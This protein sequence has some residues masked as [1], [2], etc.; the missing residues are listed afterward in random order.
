MQKP[1]QFELQPSV[2]NI[3]E[4]KRADSGS[5][6]SS[7]AAA[8]IFE[9][10]NLNHTNVWEETRHLMIPAHNAGEFKLLSNH[11]ESGMSGMGSEVRSV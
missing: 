10:Q 1:H 4:E 11:Q 7:S 8:D 3:P 9:D 2:T 6:A 5:S